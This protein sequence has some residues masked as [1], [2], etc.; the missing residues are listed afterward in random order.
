MYSFEDYKVLTGKIRDRD[1]FYAFI[2]EF[3]LLVAE[4]QSQEQAI[5]ELKEKFL[6]RVEALLKEGEPLPVPG[7][8]K[9]A[10]RFASNQQVEQL[11]PF[12]DDFWMRIFGTS[13]NTSFVSGESNLEAWVNMYV[14]GGRQELFAR[15][16]TIYGVDISEYWDEPVPVVLRKIMDST[17]TPQ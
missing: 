11:R 3:G 5:H 17:N 12:V 2:E 16:Q 14:P 8:G 13:Y 1:V 9:R 15:V 7:S 6:Q 4:G 10:I